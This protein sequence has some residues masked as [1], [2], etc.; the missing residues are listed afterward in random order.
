MDPVV[1]T[2]IWGVI[3]FFLM[4]LSAVFVWAGAGLGLLASNRQGDG[5]FIFGGVVGWVVGIAWSVFCIIQVVLH[6][7]DLVRHLSG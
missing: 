5:A 2:V 3:W 4:G 1:A 6:I 7:V